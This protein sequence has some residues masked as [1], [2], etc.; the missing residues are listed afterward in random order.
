[1]F[2]E[3]T[4]SIKKLHKGE[5]FLSFGLFVINMLFI[6]N[7]HNNQLIHMIKIT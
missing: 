3:L 4:R 7:K 1:M 5:S 2:V 6:D